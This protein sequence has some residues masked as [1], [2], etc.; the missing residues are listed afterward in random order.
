M[1]EIYTN[2][3]SVTA[4]LGVAG[5]DSDLALDLLYELDTMLLGTFSVTMVSHPSRLR[6]I[7][8]RLRNALQ[9]LFRRPYWSR[10]WIVQEIKLAKEVVV[11]CG[12]R[13]VLWRQIL[14]TIK[15]LCE[16]SRLGLG[17][18]F[19]DVPLS[20]RSEVVSP[21]T[22][23]L[24]MDDQNV[25][26][27]RQYGD[28]DVHLVS[29]MGILF[30]KE[31]DAS[32]QNGAFHFLRMIY[33]YCEFECADIRDKVYGLMGLYPG[34]PIEVDYDKNVLELYWDIVRIG[35]GTEFNRARWLCVWTSRLDDLIDAWSYFYIRLS[36]H[37]QV[38]TPEVLR[39]TGEALKTVFAA[40]HKARAAE[41][42]CYAGEYHLE[43]EE[44]CSE[45]LC[46]LQ[47]ST[48][49]FAT[50][51]A[52]LMRLW[53]H[54][55]ELERK[56]KRAAR[57]DSVLLETPPSCTDVQM[58]RFES[59]HYVGENVEGFGKETGALTLRTLDFGF[60]DPDVQGDPNERCV[61]R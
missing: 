17:I 57:R 51:D 12:T 4:W 42:I 24:F 40:L 22:R 53:R 20:A 25:G 36:I 16:E 11:R 21:A 14:S 1:S 60:T 33:M 29:T 8:P 54:L 37:I 19:L 49:I 52:K 47:T 46:T 2:A 27:Y 10:L 44:P 18:Q 23:T 34:Y 15:P 13:K 3:H 9:K 61:I 56:K 28:E 35:L 7:T 43:I 48:D 59:N 50:L 41:G 30:G 26:F 38:D 5:E 55:K 31:R 39:S 32:G 58:P 6:N 45:D